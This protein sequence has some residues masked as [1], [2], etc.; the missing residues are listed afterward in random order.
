MAFTERYIRADAAGGGDGTTDT[1]SGANGA[2]TFAEAIAAATAGMRMNMKAGTYA[3]TTTTRTL[4]VAGTA[5]A[6]LWWRGFKVTPGD[7]DTN[8]V[9]VAG[10][11]IPSITFTTG[12]LVISALQQIFSNLDISGACVA[13]NGQV[14]ITGGRIKMY[15]VRIQNTAANAA[16]RAITFA[17][18]DC[19]A[20]GCYFKATTTAAF[21][22][23]NASA[24]NTLLGCTIVNG[25]VGYIATTSPANLLHCVFDSPAGDAIQSSVS[26][27]VINCAFYAPGGHGINFTSVPGS[28]VIANCYFE[29][30]NQASKAAITNTSGTNAALIHLVGNAYYNCTANIS[31]ITET[32]AIF[33]NGS[34]GSAAFTA[35]GSQ[36]F[37]VGT[38]AKALGFPG[39]FENTSAYQ[40]YLDVGAVQRQEPAGGGSTYVIN[41]IRNMFLFNETEP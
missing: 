40:G 6:L 7:Q 11:D 27:Y 13:T 8:N 12:Q 2:W 20:A 5:T 9:A 15:R 41:Q 3:N 18:N 37:S 22:V 24:Y 29:N 33:D 4:S 34:L 10:T 19:L 35:P 21:C 32:F 16:A 30:V 23:G 26:T 25:A 14:S 36:D 39:K 1:N 31:G 28:A 38:V 17:A